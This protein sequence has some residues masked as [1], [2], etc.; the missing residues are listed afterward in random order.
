MERMLVDDD[1][2][3]WVR[4]KAVN[5]PTKELL[6]DHTFICR[7]MN[8]VLWGRSKRFNRTKANGKSL[9]LAL[10][11]SEYTEEVANMSKLVCP[12]CKGSL[13]VFKGKDGNT[14]Y[15]CTGCAKVYKE[16]PK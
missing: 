10:L 6:Q 5:T 9:G 3:E 16:R 4:Q 15:R 2:R 1:F 8:D 12:S 11:E 7:L 14:E 13:I